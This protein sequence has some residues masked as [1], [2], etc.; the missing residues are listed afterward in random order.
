MQYLGIHY[1]NVHKW[2][3]IL[4][5]EWKSYM[6]YKGGYDFAGYAHTVLGIPTE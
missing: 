5:D 1:L 2:F 3:G 6:Y 4:N